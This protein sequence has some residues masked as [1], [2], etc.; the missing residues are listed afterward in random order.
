MG[1]DRARITYDEKQQYRGVIAQQG[2]VTLEADWNESQQIVRATIDRN[3]R[4]TVGPTGTPDDGYGVI[5]ASDVVSTGKS[6]DFG[7]QNGTMYVGG[8]RV[9]Q[10]DSSLYSKQSES[11]W[12]DSKGDSDWHSL[13]ELAADKP[14]QEFVYLCLRE[15]EISAVEDQALLEPAIGG[16]D[17]TQRVRLI[18][19]VVRKAT[20]ET[21]CESA[22]DAAKTDWET[23]HGLQFNAS[24]MQLESMAQL[25]VVDSPSTGQTTL[26]EP[27]ADGSYLEAENQ[28]IRVQISAADPTNPDPQARYKLVWGFDNASFLY[29]VKCQEDKQTLALQSPPADDKHQP[30]AQQTVEVLRSTAQLSN[31]HYVAATTGQVFTLTEP[32]VPDAKTVKLPSPIANK[33]KSS[34]Q[35]FLRVW[36]EEKAFIPDNPVELGKTG[37]QVKLTTRSTVS[38]EKPFHVGDYWQIAIRP[39]C[40]IPIYP[41]RYTQTPQSPDGPGLWVCPLAVVE[42]ETDGKTYKQSPEDAGHHPLQDCRHKFDSLVE[43]TNRPISSETTIIKVQTL[44]ATALSVALGLVSALFTLLACLVCRNQFCQPF[45]C[46]SNSDYEPMIRN[47]NY[48][49]LHD[50]WSEG[51]RSSGAKPNPDVLVPYVCCLY[52]G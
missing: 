21:T 30:R 11:N 43:L 5:P 10:T 34:P 47:V 14:T 33:Y 25:Q 39:G 32:Y 36:E 45:S 16:S 44:N 37:L 12:L 40:S 9:V 50:T 7:I 24:T 29:R 41:E 8:M 27:A 2:R 51:P 38:D 15:Q 19:R 42:W 4:D 49:L 23:H 6:Y 28:L 18:Q 46:L 48:L 22:F 20:D 1:S 31:G 35:L 17:T 52:S 13:S 3:A 26:C